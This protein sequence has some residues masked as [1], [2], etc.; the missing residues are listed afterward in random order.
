MLDVRQGQNNNLENKVLRKINKAKKDNKQG[1][2][3]TR[4]GAMC[5]SSHS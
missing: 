1:E 3:N 4:Q 5:Y 2:N